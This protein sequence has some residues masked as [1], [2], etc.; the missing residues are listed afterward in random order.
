MYDQFKALSKRVEILTTG[1][2]LNKEP[3]ELI[4]QCITAL[5]GETGQ[6]YIKSGGLTV[7]DATSTKSSW[8]PLMVTTS[9]EVMKLQQ[10]QLIS[11]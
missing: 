5:S 11:S 6:T 8:M 2:A 10:H 4:C 9:P 1:M 3:Q 7:D